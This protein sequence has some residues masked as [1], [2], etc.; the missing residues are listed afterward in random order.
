MN[1]IETRMTLVDHNMPGQARQVT[2]SVSDIERAI[3]KTVLYSDLFDYALALD[4]VTHYLIGVRATGEEVR[5]QLAR[6]IWLRDRVRVVDEYVIACGREALVP[7]R[8][9][10]SRTSDR[11]WMR[12]RRFVRVLSALPFVRFVGVTGALAMN[13]CAAGDDIDVLIVT[14]PDRVWLT[15]AL[16]IALVYVGRLGGDTLCPNYVISENALALETHSL[17]VAHEFTQMAPVYGGAVYDRMRAANCWIAAYQPNA[18]QPLRSEPEYVPG[19][20]ARTIK[21]G[22]EWVLAGG[23]GDRLEA[24]EMQRKLRKF[25]PKMGHPDGDAIL[26]HDHVKGHFDDYGG[27]VMRLYAERLARYET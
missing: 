7:R 13:N 20:I 22:L 4:E 12:A 6:S 15:R 25:Q 11:L 14:A 17:F 9:D 21:R 18:A 24:W 19:P 26:D 2:G 23:P 3:L 27:P 8:R 10:R 5:A 1:V 16:S